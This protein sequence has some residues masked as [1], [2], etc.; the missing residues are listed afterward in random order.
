MSLSIWFLFIAQIRQ[1][2]HKCRMKLKSL[3]KKNSDR[4]PSIQF[5]YTKKRHLCAPHLSGSYTV[6]AAVVL[7]IFLGLMTFVIFYM[8]VLQVE[9]GIQKA[10]D[11]S[12]QQVAVMCA[13]KE[14][15]SLGEV[16]LLNNGKLIKEKVPL[17]YIKGGILGISYGK[18]RVKGN[19]ID[20]RVSYDIDF[21][22]QF[23]GKLKWHKEQY[24]VNRKWIGWDMYEEGAM[25]NYVYITEY[26][27]VYH[28]KRQCPYLNP[29]IV[30]IPYSQ[31]DKVRNDSGAKYKTCRECGAKNQKAG[32]AYITEY[33]EVYHRSVTC[34]GLK[35]TIHR[36]PIT[37]VEGRGPCKKCR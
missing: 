36:V 2:M 13:T 6:E 15:I 5:P 37:E 16:I 3:L 26:G 33:G 9:F 4:I 23:F 25:E 17:S 20:L 31:V 11:E 35:R 24:S 27:R 29:T 18:S 30:A 32:I 1:I 28:M 21:P 12:G 7:P 34:S 10:L 19:Y 8:R 14:D 22:I